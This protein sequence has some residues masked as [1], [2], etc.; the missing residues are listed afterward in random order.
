[1][2]LQRERINFID[3]FYDKYSKSI[4]K[5]IE[6]LRRTQD[7]TPGGVGSSLRYWAPSPFF[8]EKA[9]GAYIWELDGNKYIDYSMCYAAMLHPVCGCLNEPHFPLPRIVSG[10]HDV[11]DGKPCPDCRYHRLSPLPRPGF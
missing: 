11:I 9:K 3:S 8:V 6:M 5:S 10:F 7:L 2:F 1:M 4:P